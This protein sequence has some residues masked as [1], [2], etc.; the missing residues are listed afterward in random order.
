MGKRT[1]RVTER[2]RETVRERQR[3]QGE[4]QGQ[5]DRDRQRE[6]QTDRQTNSQREA[7]RETETDRQSERDRESREGDRDS[8]R[9]TDSQRET[10]RAGRAGRETETVRD[11]QTNSQRETER[12]RERQIE[13]VREILGGERT[14]GT[15]THRQIDKERHRDREGQKGLCAWT[16]KTDLHVQ[17][18]CVCLTTPGRPSRRQQ[19]GTRLGLPSPGT[20][21]GLNYNLPKLASHVGMWTARRDCSPRPAGT[22]AGCRTQVQ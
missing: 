10:E 1:E 16:G 19:T 12:Q 5:A 8:Q 21:P 13:T 15:C 11:R 7:G 17:S 22:R 2:D 4:R 18:P 9:Q 6:R 14:S 3:E 20:S